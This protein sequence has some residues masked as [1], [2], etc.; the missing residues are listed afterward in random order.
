MLFSYVAITIMAGEVSQQF[1]MFMHN[2]HDYP[3]AK[4]YASS[5][6]GMTRKGAADLYHA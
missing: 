4:A 6:N 2:C 1:L 3:S 5:S